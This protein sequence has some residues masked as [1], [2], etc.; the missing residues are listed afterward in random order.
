MIIPDVQHICA[1]Q[2]NAATLSLNA[3]HASYVS[4]PNE[5]ADFILNATK[6]KNVIFSSNKV[7]HSSC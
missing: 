4:H 5:I 2:M 1:E 6:E 7:W 3:S